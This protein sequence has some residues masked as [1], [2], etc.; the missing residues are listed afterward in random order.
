LIFL[1]LVSLEP[2]RLNL[3][4]FC[5]RPSWPNFSVRLT[6]LNFGHGQLGRIQTNFGLANS[7]EYVQILVE[8][9]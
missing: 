8:L 3:A 6:R 2:T 5:S 7:T 1:K 4:E 9:N